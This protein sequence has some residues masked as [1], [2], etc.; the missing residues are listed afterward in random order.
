MTVIASDV[1]SG[2][3]DAD[4]QSV[5]RDQSLFHSLGVGFEHRDIRPSE[6]HADVI[7]PDA[8]TAR[9]VSEAVN[10]AISKCHRVIKKR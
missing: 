4:P 8:L 9:Q 3:G 10:G 5:D 6:P 7:W 1:R 2:A